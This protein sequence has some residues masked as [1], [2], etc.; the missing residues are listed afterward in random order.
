MPN[1]INLRTAFK[2]PL[3]INQNFFKEYSSI[4]VFKILKRIIR[5]AAMFG[6]FFSRSGILLTFKIPPIEKDEIILD[7]SEIVVS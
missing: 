3:K 6:M 1:Y 4:N 2:S 5:D 7:I